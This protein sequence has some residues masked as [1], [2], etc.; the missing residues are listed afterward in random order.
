M[1]QNYDVIIIGGYGLIGLPMG[2]VLADTG[3]Q[4]GL[5][6]ID[7]SKEP[8][9]SAGTMPFL[10]YDAEPILQRVI[11]KTLHLVEMH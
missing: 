1:T 6:D 8:L 7:K 5:Y 3:L 4:V 9:I 11:G 2:I 10:E